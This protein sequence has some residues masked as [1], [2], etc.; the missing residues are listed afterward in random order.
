MA[1]WWGGTPLVHIRI[2]RKRE[3]AVANMGTAWLCLDRPPPAAAKRE[4][5]ARSWN[6]PGSHGLVWQLASKLELRLVYS[7]RQQMCWRAASWD[8]TAP[9]KPS[10]LWS[11]WHLV[12]AKGPERTKG[13]STKIVSWDPLF[14]TTPNIFFKPICSMYAIFTYMYHK[15]KPHVG[16]YSIHGAYIGKVGLSNSL[17]FDFYST[18][19]QTCERPPGS[20]TLHGKVHLQ[21]TFFRI[22]SGISSL[23]KTKLFVTLEFSFASKIFFKAWTSLFATR[24]RCRTYCLWKTSGDHQLRLVV[25]SIIYIPGGAGFLSS[26][27]PSWWFQ[28][29]WKILV[30]LDHFPR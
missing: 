24:S 17:Q 18:V 2:G 9:V 13:L 27:V 4:G 23:K 19:P 28:P 7:L 16:K 20:W 10:N 29:I 8:S 26:I 21:L 15:F 30:K 1:P 3:N 22:C 25:Y 11:M 5:I 6:R 14:W 12:K